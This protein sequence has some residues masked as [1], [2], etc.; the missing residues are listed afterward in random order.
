MLKRLAAAT[1]VTLA[2][3][4]MASA[5]P[6]VI[7]N[8]GVDGAG[9]ALAD[10][11]VDPHWQ[12]IAGT[13]AFPGPNAYVSNPGYPIP[14]WTANTAASKWISPAAI[15]NQEF[16]VFDTY[17]Y[18]I[19]F[20]LTGLI[21]GSASLSGQWASDNQTMEIR[22]NG[23][24]ILGAPN[25]ADSTSDTS[26]FTTFDPFSIA[27]GFVAG[28][29]TLDFVVLNGGG[30]SGLRVEVAGSADPVP[31]PG[32]LLLLGSGITGLVLRRRRRS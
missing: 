24:N 29:N 13:L 5:T 3:A 20:D 11:T 26:C 30:P 10:G 17:I 31:E 25:C 19:T 14:P 15:A 4:G 21:P 6:I 12:I 1:F 27:S 18:R 7:F 8:T 2:M 22:L 32:T 16:G 23:V 28:T 9:V